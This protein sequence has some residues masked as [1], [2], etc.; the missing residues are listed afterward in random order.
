[1][2][3][4]F[5]KR[6]IFFD[7]SLNIPRGHAALLYNSFRGQKV[8]VSPLL[9]AILEVPSLNPPLFEQSFQYKIGPSQAN[10]QTLGQFSLGDLRLS[11]QNAQYPMT[12][13]FR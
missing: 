9:S 3:H 13:F 5:L 2:L 12:D 4:F 10:A 11:F 6:F 1:M 7:F 8:S